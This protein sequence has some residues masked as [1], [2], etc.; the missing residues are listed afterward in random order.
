MER[1]EIE[2]KLLGIGANVSRKGFDYIVDAVEMIRN[3]PK[4]L[5]R[6][7]KVYME[8]GK[9]RGTKWESVE[10]CIRGEIE[11]IYDRNKELPK[12]L[13]PDAYSGKL[14][15]KEFLARFVRFV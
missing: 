9:A 15:N 6:I 3:D 2:K 8:I 1:I 13:E 11:Q 7:T 10:R 12:V 5:E 4:C 14:V